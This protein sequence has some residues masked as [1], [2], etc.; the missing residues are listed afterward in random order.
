VL[1][2]AYP[3][4]LVSSFHAKTKINLGGLSLDVW[5]VRDC[6]K[7]VEFLATDTSVDPD[8]WQ[9]C[10][11]TVRPSARKGSK[12]K[13]MEKSNAVRPPLDPDILTNLWNRLTN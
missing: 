13:H 11:I 3:A 10:T 7:V 6:A 4:R 8:L 5:N 12:I 2:A 1:F 9:G